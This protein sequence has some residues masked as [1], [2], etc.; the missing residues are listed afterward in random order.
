[1]KKSLGETKS[2]KNLQESIHEVLIIFD[3][4][5][6]LLEGILEGIWVPAY[7]NHEN[8]EFF[9]ADSKSLRVKEFSELKLANSSR[10]QASKFK[11]NIVDSTIIWKGS[12]RSTS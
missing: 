1:M 5:S 7:A 4:S 3:V 12:M 9:V 6:R 11:V 10:F 2:S 8:H